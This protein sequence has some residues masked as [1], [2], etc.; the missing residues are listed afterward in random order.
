MLSREDPSPGLKFDQIV[1]QS[2]LV[3]SSGPPRA[4]AH[5]DAD[6]TSATIGVS[7]LRAVRPRGRATMAGEA[8]AALR[9]AIIIGELQPGA[10][11]R[12]EEL[13]ESLGMS[14]SPIR[15]AIRH[16]ETV[17]LAE[18]VAYRGARVTEL[19]S[20]DMHDVYEVRTV[21]EVLAVRRAAERF[22]DEDRAR[23]VH[24]LERLEEAYRRRDHRGIVDGNTAFHTAV[25]AAAGSRWI[26]RLLQ[27]TFETTERYGAAVLR[28]GAPE[29]TKG[30]EAA[31]HDA[32]LAAC[33]A[34]DPDGAEAAMREHLRVFGATF[35]EALAEAGA[36]AAQG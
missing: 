24:A 23:S 35:E 25:A 11:L 28:I 8:V 34:Q 3:S 27:P 36:V 22:T 31:G 33:A 10:P 30:I 29:V 2:V 14:I 5:G 1:R 21:L 7:T 12:L 19:T 4:T 20:A 17:G 9:E 15:E 13:A 6:G 32:I 18:H 16:L 26:E